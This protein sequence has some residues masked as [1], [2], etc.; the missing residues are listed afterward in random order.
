VVGAAT[1]QPDAVWALFDAALVR[2]RLDD[3]ECGEMPT[4]TVVDLAG[5]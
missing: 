3:P 4:E 5:R 2:L 1:V